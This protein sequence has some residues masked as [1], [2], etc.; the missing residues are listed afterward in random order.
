MR[1]PRPADADDGNDR[2]QQPGIP[3]LGVLADGGHW[4]CDRRVAGARQV[5]ADRCPRRRGRDRESA[6]TGEPLMSGRW[7][8][9]VCSSSCSLVQLQED[10]AATHTFLERA[11]RVAVV[12]TT[13]SWSRKVLIS[14]WCLDVT[15]GPVLVQRGAHVRVHAL[16]GRAVPASSSGRRSSQ[17]IGHRRG[18]ASRGDLSESVLL[19]MSTRRTMVLLPPYTGDGSTSPAP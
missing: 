5:T 9:A 3:A 6:A 14:Q 16:A 12:E 1:R 10:L 13:G 2:R 15:H 11:A 19:S 18:D 4:H 17:R 8:D 7:L